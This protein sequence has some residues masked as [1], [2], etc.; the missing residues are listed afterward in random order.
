MSL[1]KHALVDPEDYPVHVFR[2]EPDTDPLPCIMCGRKPEPGEQVMSCNRGEPRELCAV[3]VSL[4]VIGFEDMDRS[5]SG[6]SALVSPFGPC[7]PR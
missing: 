2:V 4:A 3:C 1:P 5:D 7:S 6:F